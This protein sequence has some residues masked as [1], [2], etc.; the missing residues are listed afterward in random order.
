MDSLNTLKR[1]PLFDTMKLDMPF[2]LD[3]LKGQ[4]VDRFVKRVVGIGWRRFEDPGS[5]L[6]P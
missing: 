2:L 6:K 4:Y 1:V 3:C 5:N